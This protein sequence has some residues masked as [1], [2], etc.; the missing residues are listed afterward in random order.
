MVISN[1]FSFFGLGLSPG[2]DSAGHRPGPL[3]TQDSD[4]AELKKVL[5]LHLAFSH[6]CVASVHRVKGA[7][8]EEG[9]RADG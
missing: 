6:E 5:G 7:N 3:K 4:A 8:Q 2:T 9:D 1:S